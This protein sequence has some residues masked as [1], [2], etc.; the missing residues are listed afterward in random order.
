MKKFDNDIEYLNIVDDI[1]QNEKFIKLTN[2][3][4]HGTNRFE[5]S[6]RVSYYSYKVT[7]HLKLKYKET[8][9]GGLLHDFFENDDL[10]P[11]KQKLSMFYHPYK[12]LENAKKYFDLTNIEEDIIINHMFPTL[13]HKIPKNIESWIVSII[14]KGVAAYEFYESYGKSVAYKLQNAG[15][16]IFLLLR[17]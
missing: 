4:H 12:S 3:I 17:W 1:M 16:I 5:H 11:Q 8:A 13:P 14:D 6:L 2:C 10:T 7:K 9:R 15:L